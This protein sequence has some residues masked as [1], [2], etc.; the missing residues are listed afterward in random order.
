MDTHNTLWVAGWNL[1][2]CLPDYTEEFDSKADAE[3]WLEQQKAL[4][5]EL[6][7]E[8]DEDT[9]DPYEYFVEPIQ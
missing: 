9:T 6:M 4:Y 2:G 7:K 1:P 8:W 5:I 3:A